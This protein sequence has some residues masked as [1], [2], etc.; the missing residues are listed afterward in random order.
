[1]F[2]NIKT[3]HK[4]PFLHICVVFI[5]LIICCFVLFFD[6]GCFAVLRLVFIL[7]LRFT[8]YLFRMQLVYNAAARAPISLT[9]SSLTAEK[10]LTVSS[11]ILMFLQPSSM[12]F[13]TF[14]AKGAQVPFSMNATVLF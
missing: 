12:P 9:L 11:S 1:M 10:I 3:A 5:F 7:L 6:F 14:V 2:I 4:V 13:I 8:I